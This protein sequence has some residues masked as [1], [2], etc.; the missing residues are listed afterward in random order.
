MFRKSIIAENA[1]IYMVVPLL[2][3]EPLYRSGG[4]GIH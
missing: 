4:V 2:T 1:E 3:L